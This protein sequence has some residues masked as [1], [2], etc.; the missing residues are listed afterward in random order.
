MGDQAIRVGRG[1]VPL[2]AD[3]G[4]ALPGQN[5]TWCVNKATEVAVHLDGLISAIEARREVVKPKG[6]TRTM[7]RTDSWGELQ[8][9]SKADR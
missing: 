7:K 1:T 2:H 6:P 3:G 8:G 5:Q 9:R 4:W